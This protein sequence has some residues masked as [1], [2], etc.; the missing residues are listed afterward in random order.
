LTPQS[1]KEWVTHLQLTSK[2]R[3]EAAK[4]H[5]MQ[6]LGAYSHGD[7]FFI[8][9]EE[10]DRSLHDYLFHTNH[11]RYDSAEL[12]QQ[13]EGLSRGLAAL[14]NLY[15]GT[16]RAYHQDLKPANI[17]VVR[18]IMKIADFG[19]VEFR[20]VTVPGPGD[21]DISGVESNLIMGHY[22]APGER[23]TRQGDIW[24]LGCIISELT[25]S[26]IQSLDAI[27]QYRSERR[28]DTENL[29][30][31][32][33]PK[34]FNSRGVVKNSVLEWHKKLRDHVRNT[35]DGSITEFQ[36]RFYSDQYFVL[37]NSMF[38][39]RTR[40][41][42]TLEVP[43]AGDLSIIN[44]PMAEQIA[45]DLKRLRE[46]ALA[47]P[48]PPNAPYRRRELPDIWREI[49]NETLAGCPSNPRNRL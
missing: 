23:S 42:N 41:G 35:E 24:S 48:P 6:A 11:D 45:S 14:H 30:G 17:L 2:I 28:R 34:F 5:V 22:R 21:S 37:L 3:N 39:H 25:T 33:E 27:Q 8:L 38:R 44:A 12:W 46:E 20:P 7:I 43:S 16:K 13:I 36:K 10:A 15:H 29:S 9:Q 32:D 31:S 47:P 1:I 26:D 4:Q 40:F 19:L 18:G 49:H